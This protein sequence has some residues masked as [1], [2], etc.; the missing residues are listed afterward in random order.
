MKIQYVDGELNLHFAR[1]E[2]EQ[3]VRITEQLC[4]EYEEIGVDASQ[5]RMLVLAI[6]RNPFRVQ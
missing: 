2:L 6:K 5:I 3:A 1:E 4:D